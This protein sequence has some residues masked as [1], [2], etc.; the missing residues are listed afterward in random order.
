MST[1]ANFRYVSKPRRTKEDRRFIAGEGRFAADV[2]LAHMLHVAMVSSPYPCAEITSI[3]CEAALAAP[4]VHAVLTGDEL[5]AAT[6]PLLSGLDL[7]NIKRAPLAA[8][9]VRYAGEWVVAV[10]AESRALAEDAAELV[11]VEYDPL[12]FVIDPEQAFEPESPVVHPDHG[13]NVLFQKRWVWGDVAGD[14]AAADHTISYRARWSRCSTVPIETFAVTARWNAGRDMLDVWA[15][16]QMPKY[17]EQ[18]A[19]ALRIPVNGVNVHFDVDVGGSY[20]VK[21]G[22]RQTIIVGYLS[23]RLGR[24]VRFIEDRLENMSGGDAHGPDRIFDVNIAFDSDATMRSIR[25]RALDDV[26]CYPGRAPLQLGK[27]VGAITGPY[28]IASAQYEAI[29]VCTN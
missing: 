9:R 25:I 16:I 11:A 5:A 4:G 17:P 8:G 12:P 10:V 15:S 26:G 19:R 24:P 20:G 22:I 7:P 2:R 3:G 6:N 1:G 29:S 13:S 14:F 28:R 23:R 27:P 21:R 18:I